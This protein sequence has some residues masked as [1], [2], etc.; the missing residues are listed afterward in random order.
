MRSHEKTSEKP[1]NSWSGKF[2][3]VHIIS[4]ASKEDVEIGVEALASNAGFA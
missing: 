3:V 2:F 1:S 4:N